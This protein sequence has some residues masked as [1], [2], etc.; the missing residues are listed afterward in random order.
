MTQAETAT[1]ASAF[2]AGAIRARLKE[3]VLGAPIT[4]SPYPHAFI[5][6]VFPEDFYWRVRD[7]V[8]N[9]DALFAYPQKLKRDGTPYAITHETHIIN[10]GLLTHRGENLELW[11]TFWDGIELIGGLLE[12]RFRAYLPTVLRSMY[13]DDWGRRVMDVETF[14]ETGD[15]ND[16]DA[17]YGIAPHLDHPYKILTW[18]FYMPSDDKHLDYG[19]GIYS[20]W[21]EEP[22]KF[23]AKGSYFAQKLIGVEFEPHF[24]APFLP[25]SMVVFLNSPISYH[26]CVGGEGLDRRL[27]VLSYVS[28]TQESFK[29]VFRGLEDRYYENS[30]L[31]A[32]FRPYP[33]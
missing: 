16:G 22:E 15:I 2:D 19:T 31:D 13:P 14:V 24:T 3:T 30:R 17:E 12:K 7:A 20:P 21:I 28:Y 10:R 33:A 11:R 32:E 27:F 29:T 25:N 1:Q 26:G 23:D 18:L 5:E 6:N 9:R 4:E 8:P